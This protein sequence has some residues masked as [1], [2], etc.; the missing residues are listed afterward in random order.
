MNGKKPRQK[1]ATG[2]TRVEVGI[3]EALKAHPEGLD[4]LQLRDLLTTPED[5]Q[6][7]LDRRLRNLDP[8]YIIDRVRVGKRQV[9][10]L[11]GKREEGEWDYAVIPKD[12]RARALKD[13]RCGMCGRTVAEDGVKLHADHR[14]PRAWGGQTVAENLIALCSAC[15]EGKRNYFAS[16]DPVEM[17][18][19]IN[20][21]SPHIRLALLLKRK[22][23]E[24]VDSDF[25]E[26]VA[27]FN[28][29]QDD[30]QKR[31]RELRDLGLGI[32]NRK[33]RTDSRILSQYRLTKWADLPPESEIRKAI[34]RQELAR[35][36]QRNEG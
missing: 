24:W 36:R 34:R 25:L 3:Y 20:H 32:E 35:K 10:R 26:F 7:H 29:Y 2:L 18:D 11:V 13:G 12:L 5:P 30:W 22:A 9:Y 1:T 23:G 4:I 33:L 28:D 15:N 6:Q 8:I 16:F 27:N 31:L 14:I 19:C 17:Q 21:E